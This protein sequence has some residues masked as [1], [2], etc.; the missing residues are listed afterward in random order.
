MPSVRDPKNIAGNVRRIRVRAGLTQGQL[1]ERAE[2]ADA[3]VSRVERGRL[4]PSSDLLGK[5]AEALRVGDGR[6]RIRRS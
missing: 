6:V 4:E 5:L 1:A 3:T 2:I